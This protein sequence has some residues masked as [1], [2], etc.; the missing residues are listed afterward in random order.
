MVEKAFIGKWTYFSSRI[1]LG[2]TCHILI[3]HDTEIVL[4]KNDQFNVDYCCDSV[5][6]NIY[7]CIYLKAYMF[8]CIAMTFSNLKFHELLK[9]DQS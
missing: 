2:I 7:T 4:N 5:I 3:S 1:V 8:K 6:Y 9:F